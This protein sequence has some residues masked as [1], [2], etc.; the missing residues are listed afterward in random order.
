MAENKG[1]APSTTA[2]ADDTFEEALRALREEGR[3]AVCPHVVAG[4][5]TSEGSRLEREDPSRPGTIVSVCH[6]AP[7]AVVDR[8][9][10]AGHDAV[11]AWSALEAPSRAALLRPAIALMTPERRALMAAVL[12]LE[13]GKTRK[14]AFVE[15]DELAVLIDIY[16][17]VAEDARAFEDPLSL[18]DGAMVSRSSLRPYGV[19]GVISPFNYPMVLGAAPAVAAMLAGN[20][21]VLKP[22]HLGPRSIQLFVDLIGELDLPAGVLNVVHGGDD[23]GKQ[24]VAGDVDGIAFVGSAAAGR[25]IQHVLNA[26]PYARPLIAEMGGKNPLIVTDSADL[27]AAAN[28]ITTAAFGLSGQRCSALSRVIVTPGVHDELAELVAARAADIRIGD[29]I[30]ASVFAGPVIER[31]SAERFDAAV[32]E[33]RR[34]GRVLAGGERSDGYLAQAT[35][36]SGLPHGHRLTREELFLPLVTVG[37]VDD[38]AAA[39]AEANVTEYGLTAGIFTGDREEAEYFLRT[40]EAGCV[41]VN[42]A[43]GATTGWWPGNQTF[44]GWKA[45]GTTGKQAF[46]QWYVQQF[47]REQCRTVPAAFGV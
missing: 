26:G 21:V 25:A 24:L 15:V 30:D 23:P 3:P 33:A 44:G 20:T 14:E 11:G 32:A 1:A 28:A 5:A 36:V 37:A 27:E 13:T 6:D 31:R 10:R 39:L 34:D 19:F 2:G 41:N 7:K 43:G 4:V 47:A 38:L 17:G 29:P 22:S 46:G 8:A 45:S 16:C 35:V 9:I 12:S 18:N 40:I 42:N